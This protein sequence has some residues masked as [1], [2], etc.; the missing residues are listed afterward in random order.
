MLNYWQTAGAIFGTIYR[1]S[2]NFP[3]V[4]M[5]LSIYVRY[6]L[7]YNKTLANDELEMTWKETVLVCLKTLSVY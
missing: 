2:D 3:F 6:L 4:L 7:P 1:E 5:T